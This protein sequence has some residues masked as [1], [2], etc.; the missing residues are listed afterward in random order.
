MANSVNYDTVAIPRPTPPIQFSI[1]CS[2]AL[3]MVL[4]YLPGLSKRGSMNDAIPIEPVIKEVAPN[5]LARFSK[6]FIFFFINDYYS[7][8]YYN[9]LTNQA[10][11]C[12]FIT[13]K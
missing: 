12:N 10:K 8:Q 11:N 7:L 13:A 1:F 6:D 4:L 3:G 9:F 5:I 2:D